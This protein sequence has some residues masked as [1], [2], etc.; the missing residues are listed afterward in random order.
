[1][2]KGHCAELVL[3]LPSAISLTI[4]PMQVK[5]ILNVK[6]ESHHITDVYL[7]PLR[8]QS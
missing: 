6:C 7:F 3:Q 8:E 2:V 1:M 5:F 4:S